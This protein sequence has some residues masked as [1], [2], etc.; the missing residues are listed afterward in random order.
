MGNKESTVFSI[1]TSIIYWF[2]A[3]IVGVIAVIIGI[4]FI[5]LKLFGVIGFQWVW[6]ASPLWIGTPIVFVLYLLSE[7][8]EKH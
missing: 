6:V 4:V 5:A 7:W 3:W 1:F 8:R 2:S